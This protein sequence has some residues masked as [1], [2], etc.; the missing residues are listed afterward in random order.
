M[1][2]NCRFRRP[3]CFK[4]TYNSK[5]LSLLFQKSSS[6]SYGF[7]ILYYFIIIKILKLL[8]Y[9]VHFFKKQKIGVAGTSST[10][11]SIKVFN[12]KQQD[13]LLGVEE[14]QSQII[15]VFIIRGDNWLYGTWSVIS[16]RVTG[17]HHTVLASTNLSTH[18]RHSCNNT[19]IAVKTT[20]YMNYN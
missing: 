1:S 10:F 9:L 7:D 12:Q 6:K 19:Y 2:K 16:P 11:L 18:L 3:N 20:I 5:L 15:P 4:V 14:F 8:N 13:K 17:I